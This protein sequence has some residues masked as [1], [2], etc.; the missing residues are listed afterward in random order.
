MIDPKAEPIDHKPPYKR[1]D[2]SL[3]HRSVCPYCRVEN[4][5]NWLNH[6]QG[7]ASDLALPF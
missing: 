1:I 6:K 2:F 5:D 7:C 4:P 3:R